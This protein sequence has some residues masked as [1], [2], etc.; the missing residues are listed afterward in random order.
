[1]NK[2]KR[3]LAILV[4]IMISFTIGS[5]FNSNGNNNPPHKEQYHAIFALDE[6][7]YASI[8]FKKGELVTPPDIPEKENYEILGW[9]NK[10]G[11]LEDFT[12]PIKNNSTYYIQY[13]P[14]LVILDNEIRNKIFSSNVRVYTT[15]YNRTFYGKAKDIYTIP[16]SGVIFAS[17]N[18]NYY[19]LT[20]EHVA[21]KRGKKYVEYKIVDY[22]GNEYVATLFDYSMRSDLD[23]A[24]LKFKKKTE[25][26]HVIERRY[27][28]PIK[29]QDVIL[30]GQPEGHSNRITY[31]TVEGYQDI[32]LTNE[33]T[34]SYQVIRYNAPSGPGASGGAVLDIDF[35]LI[36]LHFASSR[37]EIVNDRKSYAI[38]IQIINEY[39]NEHI[40]K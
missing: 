22:K 16:G 21:S 33:F 1:M 37:T 38:P 34:P 10:D 27:F 26:L 32:T 31:G 2:I 28:N 24:I 39:L 11:I 3:L 15:S 9:V 19:V 5:C 4:L 7:N 13:K 14:D 18:N 17:N 30:I 6:L 8:A 40:Y 12:R 36:G 20:N 25:N 35:N 29:N 23:L